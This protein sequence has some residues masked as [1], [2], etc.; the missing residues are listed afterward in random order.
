MKQRFDEMLPF[1]VNGTLAEADRD[2]VETYLREHPKSAAEIKWYES[3]QARLR[4]DVPAVS[5][6]VG[7]ERAMKRIRGE[8]VQKAPAR[9]AASVSTWGE[10]A[11]EWIA[12]LLPQPVLRPILAGALVVVVAQAVVIANLATEVDDSS[13]IRAVTGS[14]VDK[15]PYLKVNFKADA[16]EADIRFLLVEV[17]GSLAGGPGQLG[18]WYVR[19]PE[20]QLGAVTEK[21]KASGIVEA[22]AQVDALPVRP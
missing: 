11:R 10:R 6:E 12:S 13:E 14:V 5:S 7:L 15:G 22:V 8:R 17:N 18:D 1:Y 19:I 4:E 2:W 9:P 20:A 16:R 3:L 21:L